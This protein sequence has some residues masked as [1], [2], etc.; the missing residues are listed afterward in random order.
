MS[1]NELA[2]I[3][4]LTLAGILLIAAMSKLIHFRS[5]VAGLRQYDLAAAPL[6][7]HIAALVVTAEALI[8]G[9]LLVN[10][11]LAFTATAASALFAIFAA[12]VFRLLL[13]R[14]SVD[15][16]CF[17][18][19]AEE[20]VGIGTMLRLLL[21][22]GASILLALASK[23]QLAVPSRESVS[24]S[25]LLSVGLVILLIEL[26]SLDAALAALR[27]PPVRALVDGR[28]VSLKQA[29]L[30]PAAWRASGIAVRGRY[31]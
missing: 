28:R 12:V 5:F 26:G 6:V 14:R 24:P 31:G 7:A 10:L 11:A 25:V 29:P 30:E 4:R 21:L 15:C 18:L 13:K 16:H 27:A 9:L 22:G 2:P 23:S 3:L 19:F 20:R 8:G 1:L 17:E